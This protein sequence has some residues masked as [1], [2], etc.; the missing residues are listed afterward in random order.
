ML[1]NGSNLGFCATAICSGCPLRWKRGAKKNERTLMHAEEATLP[2][3]V[4]SVQWSFALL[5]ERWLGCGGRGKGDAEHL[6][7][8]TA[9][10]PQCR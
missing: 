1:A 4:E 7:D 9:R 8:A 6:G 3:H 10:N 5:L 2:T